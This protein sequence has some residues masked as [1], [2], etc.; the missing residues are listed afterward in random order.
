MT[1]LNA[2]LPGAALK[3]ERRVF[4]RAFHRPVLI[5]TIVAGLLSLASCGSASGDSTNGDA[6]N[7]SITTHI[8]E[9]KQFKFVPETLTVKKGDLIIWKNLDVVPHTA[10]ATEKPWDSGNL[11]HGDAWSLVVG[12]V[13]KTNY[14]CTFHPVMKGT[15]VVTE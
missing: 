13:G 2:K 12:E 11:N 15:V 8:V 10:T 3:H 5:A 6:A 1:I 14:I 9:I 7:E 4:L